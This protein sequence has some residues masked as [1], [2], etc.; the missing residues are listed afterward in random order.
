M[1]PLVALALALGMAL[2][3]STAAQMTSFDSNRVVLLG[4]GCCKLA[5]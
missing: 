5:Q 1:K 3:G 4:S 2:A